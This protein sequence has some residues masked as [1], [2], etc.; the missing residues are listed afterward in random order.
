MPA[1]T[2]DAALESKDLPRERVDVPEWG[3]GA[4]LFVRGMTG[5]EKDAWEC[6]CLKQR[7][8]FHSENGF[9][10]IRASVV[11]RCAVDD[12]GNRIFTDADLD[13]VGA[14]NGKALDR[15]WTI[16]VKRSGITPDDIEQLKN[17]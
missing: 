4:Y 11:V 1:I 7:E 5:T 9:P 6:Y 10:G 13:I 12:D 16:A 15:I 17:D 14:K 3:E 2:R 8:A